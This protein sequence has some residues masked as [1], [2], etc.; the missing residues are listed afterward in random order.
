M[1]KTLPNHG[2]L[3]ATSVTGTLIAPLKLAF[4]L[5]LFMTMPWLLWQIWLFIAPG[6]HAYEKIR[7]WPL[8][9]ASSLLFYVGIGFCY[10]I[11]LPLMFKF[12][13]G[14]TPNY[15]TMT[16]DIDH[17]LSFCL[18]LFLAFGICFEMPIITL[19]LITTNL[20][21]LKSIQQ[22]RPYVLVIAFTVGM[23]LTPPDVLSQILLAVPLYLLFEL[24]ILI[25]KVHI[26]FRKQ[27]QH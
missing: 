20:L 10:F 1:L 6:L 9:L 2:G 13:I 8:L 3:I 24:G 23:L 17:Y 4:F 16:P 15:I 18:K 27:I 11:V 21:S 14:I 26:H 22:K 12:F 7:I 5:A 25:A 19:V